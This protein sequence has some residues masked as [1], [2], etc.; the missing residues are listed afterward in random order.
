MEDLFSVV[1]GIVICRQSVVWTNFRR[2]TGRKALSRIVLKVLGQLKLEGKSLTN[3][4]RAEI[5]LTGQSI[6]LT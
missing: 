3:K 2:Q 5:R 6:N 4:L 1:P